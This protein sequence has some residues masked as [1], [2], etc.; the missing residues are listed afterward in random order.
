MLDNFDYG[1]ELGDELI[2]AKLWPKIGER[3]A[4][5]DADLLPY[6]VGYSI[7]EMMW[8]RA[9][10]RVTSGACSTLSDTPEFEEV[11]EKLCATY[12]R[13]VTSAG[14]D[15]AIPFLTKSDANYRLGI[16]FSRPYK[17]TRKAEKPPFF[18]E[19]REFFLSEIGG[20]LADGEEADDLISIEANTRNRAISDQGVELGSATHREFCDFVIVSTDKDL[21]INCGYHYNPVLNV[22][23]WVTVMGQLTPQWDDKGSIKKL[24]G[25]GRKFFYAQML[26]GDQIDNYTGI[27]R[28]RLKVIYELLEPLQ[29]EQQL[30]MA[31]LGAYKA[32][33]GEGVVVDNYRGTKSYFDKYR[34]IHGKEPAD[35]QYFVGRSRFMK[36]YELMLEQGRLAHMQTFKGDIWRIDKSPVIYG[37]QQEFWSNDTKNF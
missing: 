14:C 1:A 36:P 5:V 6:T 33:Y 7:D 3:T 23:T 13:W 17:G 9:N 27:P 29:T 37:D 31:V 4:L 18:Y 20:V 26:M 35:Y 28:M 2:H 34:D 21:Q 8:L 19:L 30:Y 16:A 32:K 10:N 25:C 12:N 15:S 11:K 24:R 22:Q